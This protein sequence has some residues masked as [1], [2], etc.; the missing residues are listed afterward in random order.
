MHKK[1]FFILALSLFSISAFG[2]FSTGDKLLEG[3]FSV[4]QI[5]SSIPTSSTSEVTDK[6]RIS[7]INP[8]IAFFTSDDFAILVGIGFEETSIESY[9]FL[10]SLNDFI[11]IE[12]S[13][14]TLLFT[15]GIRSFKR[16]TDDF[17]FY[18]EF[19]ISMGYGWNRSDFLTDSDLLVFESN[20]RHGVSFKLNNSFIVSASTRS[21]FF[22]LEREKIE[23]TDINIDTYQF[24][25]SNFTAFGLS[26]AYKF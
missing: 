15:P 7:L 19:N 13:E 3:T 16:L 18:N 23:D 17:L 12:S 9:Q 2:Q 8:R 21:L 14:I 26:I 10:S 11:R 5:N 25:F 20:L 22:R 24:G 4:S 6:R 1:S